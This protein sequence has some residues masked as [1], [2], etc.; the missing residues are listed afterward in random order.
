MQDMQGRAAGCREARGERE[1]E[2]VHMEVDEGRM[3]E[4]VE[5]EGNSVGRELEVKKKK[6][7]KKEKR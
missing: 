5:C 1:C 7:K 3:Q 6:E 2:P 4:V